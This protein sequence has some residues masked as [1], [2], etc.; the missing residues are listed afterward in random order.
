MRLKAIIL[1]NFRRYR[2]KTRIPLSMLTALIGRNDSGKST[3]LEA[4]DIFFEGD[5]VKIE[6]GDACTSGDNTNVRIG[7]IF[8]DLPDFLDLDHGARTTLRG[9]YLLNSSGDLEIIKVFN[10][11]T[12]KVASPKIF[13]RALHPTADGVSDLLQKK[14]MD[15]KKLVSGRDLTT[16]CQLNNNPSMRLALYE[17]TTDLRCAE[18][19]VPLND[20]DAKN[21]WDAIKRT[22]PLYAL[23]RSDRASSDQDPEVQNPMKL[24]IQSAL[25]S[26]T[27]EL[28]AVTR[29]VEIMA[30]ETANRTI[31]QLRISFPDLA[32]ASV[33]KPQFRKPS[34]STVFKLDLE[35]DD[36]IPLN[37]RGSGVRRLV[38]LSFFQAEAARLREQR[39]ASSQSRVPVI[40]AIEE[41][42]TSQHP[43]N[44]ERIIR[45]FRGLADSGEQ[46]LLT[47]HVPGL[48]RLLPLD[49]LRF[50]DTNPT[51]GHVRVREGTEEVFSDVAKALGV[52]PEASNKLGVKVA[53][54]V[55]GPTDIDAL[56]SFAIVLKESG[57]LTRFD[58]TKVFW[59]IG[60][61]STLRDWIE[62]K[63]LDG[64][65]I[66]QIYL[67][68]SDCTSANLSP[69]ADKEKRLKEV[70][71]RNGCTAFMTR[72]RTIEN[73]VHPDAVSRASNGKISIPA[74][75][76]LDHDN[77]TK[78]FQSAFKEAKNA[79]GN[80]PKFVPEDHQGHK[81]E[82]S[83][84]DGNCK[85]IITSYIMR[86]MT[87]DEIGKRGQYTGSTGESRNEVLDWLQ[88]IEKHL[89]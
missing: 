74:E 57:H 26:L 60:G 28:D 22:L 67:F 64:L 65:G 78:V 34:W 31:E 10:C 46:V 32:L 53:V 29:K 73:Y 87:A 40:Y 24:A 19:D 56:I 23:F 5:T 88:A 43:E 80:I 63:Y 71:A 51:S 82:M 6:P 89:Y 49:S 83:D 48:A 2:S 18:V 30:E 79:H 11:S 59:T 4:L 72:K 7:A 37:K 45:A 33:L 39:Q 75:I 35:S 9:E 62:R 38:L 61:G 86:H 58:D 66:P 13:A 27:D 76:D 81:L 77:L 17:A 55:E 16:S 42:E 52:L 20:A 68:D 36:S 50:V 47:T 85:K 15:L 25:A 14:N 12:Q 41:P 8:T 84:S 3:I 54:A 1:E 21:V 69:S 70:N 44:Q